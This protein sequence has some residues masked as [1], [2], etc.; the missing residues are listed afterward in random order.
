MKPLPMPPFGSGCSA[1]PL[2]GDSGAQTRKPGT[3]EPARSTH[4]QFSFYSCLWPNLCGIHH[5][6][7][8]AKEQN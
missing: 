4:A 2:H 7:S 6:F 1:E 5:Y 8:S 3:G